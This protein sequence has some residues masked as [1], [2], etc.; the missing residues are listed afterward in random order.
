MSNLCAILIVLVIIAIPVL[1]AIL[2]IRALL[3]K[4]IKKLVIATLICVGSIIPLALLGTFTD[5]TTR[6]NHEYE[7]VETIEPTCTEKGK[8]VRVCSLCEHEKIDKTDSVSHSYT[9]TDETEPTCTGTG[10]IVKKCALCGNEEIERLDKI[11]HSWETVSVVGATC[12][13]QGEVV[14][15]CTSCGI[16]EVEHDAT[17]DHVWVVSSIVKASCDKGGYT[18][19]RCETCSSTRQTNETKALGHDMKESTR[20]EPTYDKEGKI[21]KKCTRCNH[22]DTETLDKLERIVIKFDGLEL[23]FG[24][25]SFTEVD[26]MFSEYD[27]KSVVKIPVTVKNTSKSPHSLN[28]F[29]Y[30]L[31]GSNGSESADV[32]YLLADDISEGGE[33]LSGKSYTKYFHIVYDGDGIYTIAFDDLL[34]E[35]ETVEIYVKK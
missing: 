26:N 3:K 27:K 9:I 2:I 30:T 13:K 21:V 12:S 25:Y 32:G 4:P 35:K 6:C 7:L 29:Y 14:K 16:E 10:K 23:T 28:M 18:E 22:E 33:L 8:V 15:K 19:E 1:L 20:I 34:F 11:D 5:P 31:F 17:T 24:D